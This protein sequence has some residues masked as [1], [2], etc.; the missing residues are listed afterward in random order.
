MGIALLKAFAI[1]MWLQALWCSNYII[2]MVFKYTEIEK[3]LLSQSI[4]G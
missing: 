3:R 1:Y 2:G 4:Y